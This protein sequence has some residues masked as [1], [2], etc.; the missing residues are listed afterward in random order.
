MDLLFDLEIITDFVQGY[1]SDLGLTSIFYSGKNECQS[2]QV[3]L[4]ASVPRLYPSI[5]S[6]DIT[7]KSRYLSI[8]DKRITVS[9]QCP[10]ATNDNLIAVQSGHHKIILVDVYTAITTELA[11]FSKERRHVQLGQEP[12]AIG[13]VN[14][15]GVY[16]FRIVHED[17]MYA[18]RRRVN[19]ELILK[20]LGNGAPET[21]DLTGLYAHIREQ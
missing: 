19:D 20:N 17:E 21:I 7:V 2:S 8:A 13:I 18:F 9:S 5:L 11:D 6:T 14:E 1:G 16:A 3:F 15:D 4:A 10:S 12:M